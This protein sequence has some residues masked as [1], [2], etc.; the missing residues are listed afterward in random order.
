MAKPP[1]PRS[2]YSRGG[3]RH[4]APST[5]TIRG[6]GSCLH[7]GEFGASAQLGRNG[8]HQSRSSRYNPA[9]PNQEIASDKLRCCRW[10]T[11]SVGVPSSSSSLISH[12]KQAHAQ[13]EPNGGGRIRDAVDVDFVIREG[14]RGRRRRRGR[15]REAPP[16][17]EASKLPWN[18]S[19]QAHVVDVPASVPGATH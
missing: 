5:H 15:L 1:T 11:G 10:D 18:G 6:A 4:P 17:S 3:G 2:V 14:V 13:S 9:R 16:L 8:A 19:T 12:S 7:I